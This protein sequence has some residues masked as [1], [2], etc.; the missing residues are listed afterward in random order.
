MPSVEQCTGETGL[1]GTELFDLWSKGGCARAFVNLLNSSDGKLEY[2]KDQLEVVQDKVVKLFDTY[3]ITN[4]ITPDVLSEEYNPFQDTLLEFCRDQRLPGACHKQLTKFCST[5]TRKDALVEPLYANFCGCYVPPDEKY[6]DLTLGAPEWGKGEIPK[7]VSTKEG[8]PPCP[9]KSDKCVEQPAC[10]PL[11][12][13]ALTVPKSNP[14]TGSIIRCPQNI[15]VIDAAYI[16]MKGSSVGGGLNFNNICT[17]C[18]KADGCLC[19][20]SGVNIGGTLSDMGIGE[21]F[22]QLCGE[23]SVCLVEDSEGDIIKMGKCDDYVNGEFPPIPENYEYYWSW[24]ILLIIITIIALII[25]IS[26]RFNTQR[27]DKPK[28]FIERR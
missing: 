6:L 2:N 25:S 22:N 24:I 28:I 20:I 11:C 26:A 13:R 16:N 15:C 23:S 12:H 8:C 10:D 9:K 27:V 14:E 7:C 18:T 3:N 1:I 17:G 4:T 21:N 19:V 5:I